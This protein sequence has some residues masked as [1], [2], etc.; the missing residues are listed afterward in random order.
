M[1]TALFWIIMEQV[2]AIHDRCFRTIYMSHHKKSWILDF[3]DMTG[4][5]SQNV[6]KELPL[7]AM[8]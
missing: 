7:I 1:R 8:E 5:F 3:E 4:R 6:D 2:V